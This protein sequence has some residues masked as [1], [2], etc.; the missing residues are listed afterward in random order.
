MP[1]GADTVIILED[2]EEKNNQITFKGIAK[3][4]QNVRLAGE[5]LRGWPSFS[6]SGKTFNRI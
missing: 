6:R 4:G 2:A 3:K 5:D 1:E